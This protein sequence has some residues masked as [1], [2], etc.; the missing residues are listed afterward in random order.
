[1]FQA[2]RFATSSFRPLAQPG[3]ACPFSPT[4]SSA[5][6]GPLVAQPSSPTRIPTPPSPARFAALRACL[7]CVFTV[8]TPEP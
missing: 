7:I 2:R 4:F 3:E 6:F 8:L 1:M 5:D